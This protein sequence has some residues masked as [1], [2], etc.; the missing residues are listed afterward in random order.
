MMSALCPDRCGQLLFLTTMIQTTTRAG[1]INHAVSR[2]PVSTF[3]S[4]SLIQTAQSDDALTE[5]AQA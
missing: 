3:T 5:S 4:L 2:A 1:L